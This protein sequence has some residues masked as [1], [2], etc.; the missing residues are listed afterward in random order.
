MTDKV[1]LKRSL[2]A[3]RA[4]RGR[5]RVVDV[6][7]LQYLMIDGHG[8]PNTSPAVAEAVAALYPV[9][10]GM[11]FASKVELGRDYV[12][13]PL[14]GLWWAE[15]MRSFTAARDKTR[16]NWSLML[17]TPDWIDRPT[18]LAA[19]GRAAARKRPARLDDVRLETLAE[20]RCVQT[21]HVG[22]FDDE[23]EVLAHLHD[24]VIPD[25][26]FHMTG[27]HHEIYLSDPRRTAPARQRTILRQ[28]VAPALG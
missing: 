13:P 15:D 16:W 24:V 5:F 26:G 28:P 11:K 9:A 27:R 6:P 7:E 23:A 22:S 19:A 10:Y 12:V 8:D 25:L 17:L 18:F 3:Y 14:E 20:G 2:D 1:D 21:L 4:V